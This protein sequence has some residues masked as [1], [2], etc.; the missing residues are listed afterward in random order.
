MVYSNFLN[1]IFS[2]LIL[3]LV[4]L[5]S[6]FNYNLL[7][8]LGVIFYI[9]IVYEIIKFFKIYKIILFIYLFISF[10]NYISY[11][12][13]YFNLKIFNL[14][15]LIIIFFDSFSYF[16]GVKFGKTLL[17]K[18]ISPKK[19]LEGLIGGIIIT[20]L[21]LIFFINFINDSYDISN[22]I[23]IN[24]IIF[25]SLFGDIIQSYFKRQNHI[26][27]SSNLLSGHGGFFDRFDS[28]ISAII[29]LNIYSYLLL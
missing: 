7:F 12:N 1:R 24:L 5:I 29:A 23:F 15:I 18:K 25:L 3:L 28:F 20:N 27:D 21:L 13:N 19:T 2:S 11:F 16:V 10:I 14:M 4:Y 6:L 26:K 17:F 22:F 9:V 8:L